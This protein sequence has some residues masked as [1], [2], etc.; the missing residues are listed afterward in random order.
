MKN[1]ILIIITLLA[2]LVI[3]DFVKE[4]LHETPN[5]RVERINSEANRECG[6]YE[7]Q[8]ARD[9]FAYWYSMIEDRH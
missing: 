9:C 5:Q 6:R 1:T 3:I 7:N 8:M 4:E 2:I